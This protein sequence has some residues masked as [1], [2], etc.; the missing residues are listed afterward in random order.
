MAEKKKGKY[1]L[2]KG[3][4]GT[5]PCAF[6]ALPE[7]CRNGANCQFLHDR[8]ASIT[9][10][11]HK[12]D[13]KSE[14]YIVKTKK[15]R[16][17]KRTTIP[18]E[19]K[20]HE[21]KVERPMVAAVPV[22]NPIANARNDS[23]PDLERTRSKRRAEIPLSQEPFSRPL[24]A[25]NLPVQPFRGR[26][27]SPMV[28][29]A[30]NGG[31]IGSKRSI[32]TDSRRDTP[33]KVSRLAE[34]ADDHAFLIGVVDVATQALSARSQT[35]TPFI[36]KAD[37]IGRTNV[38]TRRSFPVGTPT[39][40]FLD[41]NEAV[42][43]LQTSGTRSSKKLKVVRNNIQVDNSGATNNSTTSSGF[44][45]P[46]LQVLTLEE[47]ESLADRCEKHPKY[48]KDYKSFLQD[49]TWVSPKDMNRYDAI[50]Y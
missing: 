38:E 1:I 42:K 27:T 36:T 16:A 24:A 34:D 10:S 25:L 14:D 8:V 47:W 26:S 19:N 30:N 12:N 39:E 6:F 29:P 11:E 5:K 45:L 9:G 22:K 44:D 20:V 49:S 50:S 23:R 2:F 37:Q 46:P 33:R 48:T 35:N 31:A 15:D 21:K 7:G 28:A 13:E 18:E 43:R 41:P 32:S 40:L 3:D 4:A 17:S